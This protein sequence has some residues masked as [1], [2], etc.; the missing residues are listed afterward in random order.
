MEPTFSQEAVQ[1]VILLSGGAAII[2]LTALSIVL[3]LIRLRETFEYRV[4]KM[5][6]KREKTLARSQFADDQSTREIDL[7][8][9]RG[10]LRHDDGWSYFRAGILGAGVFALWALF[11][12]AHFDGGLGGLSKMTCAA[13]ALIAL[14]IPVACVVSDAYL[15]GLS[16]GRKSRTLRRPTPVQSHEHSA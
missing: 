11:I 7:I 10:R 4:R 15:L 6:D 13:V 14:T 2:V 16:R 9:V 1:S 5:R 12:G 8:D 3:M